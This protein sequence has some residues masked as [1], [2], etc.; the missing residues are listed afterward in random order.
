M[1]MNAELH[2]IRV[3]SLG[4]FG[5]TSGAWAGKSIME[6]FYFLVKAHDKRGRP[7]TVGGAKISATVKKPNGQQCSNTKIEDHRNGS[8]TV[9]FKAA[10]SGL[11]AI[12]V[13][14][15]NKPIQGS[16]FDLRIL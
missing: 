2:R 4:E 11:F 13:N 7:L 1:I 15:D 6:T 10:E 14:I 5:L 16:P 8:Y 12:H 9:S 3:V